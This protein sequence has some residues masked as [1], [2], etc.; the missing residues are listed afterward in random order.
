VERSADWRPGEVILDLYEVRGKTKG[1]MGVVYRVHHPVWGIDLA[2]KVPRPALLESPDALR[3]FETEAETWAGLGVHPHIVNCAYVRRI[4]NTPGVFAEWAAG[5]SVAEAIRSRSRSGGDRL[6]PVLDAAIQSAWGLAFAHGQG[7][8][9]QDVKPANLMFAADGTVKV[10][11]FG[12][13]RARRSAGESASDLADLTVSMG[14]RTPAYCSPEQA[15]SD[16]A[17]P[18]LTAATDVWSWAV[19]VIEMCTGER[20]SEHGEDAGKG[21]ADLR[22][23]G[24]RGLPP[25]PVAE[26]L[27]EC[28]REHPADRPSDLGAVAE[29][30]IE[31]HAE[32]VGR[33][34][35][36]R[37]PSQAR[38]LADGLSNRALSMLDLGRPE[39]SERLWEQA[40][41]V[42]PRHAHAVYNRGLHRWRR[43]RITDVEVV[44]ELMGIGRGHR[45]LLG[46]V[47][48]ERGASDIAVALFERAVQAD[49]GDAAAAAALAAARA[50]PAAAPPLTMEGHKSSIVSVAVSADGVLG[51]SLDAGGVL[52]T[53]DLATGECRIAI[54]VSENGGGT[55]ALAPDGSFAVV[56][57]GIRYPTVWD[58]SAP[59]S[60]LRL[61]SRL[62][63]VMDV[64][65]DG[66]RIATLGNGG[67]VRAWD[68]VSGSLLR[69]WDPQEF[70]R[71]ARPLAIDPTGTWRADL[72]DGA[73]I[74][75]S[76][77]D[78]P[79]D[80]QVLQ[81]WNVDVRFAASGCVVL[82]VA[83]DGTVRA[84]TL[85]RGEW[86]FAT[87]LRSARWP[88]QLS[89]DGR[90]AFGA[91]QWWD[92]AAA[93]CLS[94]GTRR[95]ELAALDHAGS[96]AWSALGTKVT[97][98]HRPAPFIAPWSYTR[99]RDAIVLATESETASAAIERSANLAAAGRLQEAAQ[100][101]RAARG[102]PGLRRDPRLS[103]RWRRLGVRAR[104]LRLEDAWSIG[105][106]Q[107]PS[108]Q[109]WSLDIASGGRLAL[110][111]SPRHRTPWVVDRVARQTIHPLRY[112]AG[113]VTAAAISDDGAVAV[114]AA[115]DARAIV[116]DTASGSMR[117]LIEVHQSPP[118]VA[119]VNRD[120][121]MTGSLSGE[122][123]IIDVERG[124]LGFHDAHAGSVRALALAS[125]GGIGLSS[126]E[127]GRVCSWDL[128]SGALLHVLSFGGT[129]AHRAALSRTGHR[130]V[131]WTTD[132]ELRLWNP[133]NGAS[134]AVLSGPRGSRP[135]ST[136]PHSRFISTREQSGRAAVSADGRWALT[137][138]RSGRLRTWDLDTGQCEQTLQED[139]LWVTALA[140]THDFSLAAV[141]RGGVIELWDPQA[142]N[143]V[144][145]IGPGPGVVTDLALAPDCTAMV[146]ADD[147]GGLREWA[148]D[149]EYAFPAE[150][151]PIDLAT[152]GRMPDA[153]P[154]DLPL[155]DRE[156]HTGSSWVRL[157]DAE[158]ARREL[159]RQVDRTLVQAVDPA[160]ESDC[161]SEAAAI[162]R[163]VALL[164]LPSAELSSEEQSQLSAFRQR[165]RDELA[166]LD[167]AASS[168]ERLGHHRDAEPL[169][170]LALRIRSNFDG[171]RALGTCTAGED[172]AACWS[173]LGRDDEAA[174]LLRA[175][176]TTAPL[177]AEVRPD[178]PA[179]LEADLERMTRRL[180]TLKAESTRLQE[181]QGPRAAM[182]PAETALSVARMITA[183]DRAGAP[184][185]A[186][187][188]AILGEL[189]AAAQLP[190]AAVRYLAEALVVSA[191][192]EQD[193]LRL[194]VPFDN[195][196]GLLVAAAY[197]IDLPYG[198]WFRSGDL[199][200][201]REAIDPSERGLLR[202]LM[203]WCDEAGAVF[204]EYRAP[205]WALFCHGA[206]MIVG[207]VMREDDPA[208]TGPLC[209]TLLAIAERKRAAGDPESGRHF[210]RRA[211][212]LAYN[213]CFE[214]EREVAPLGTLVAT[215]NASAP[216]WERLGEN[217]KARSAEDAAANLDANAAVFAREG[218]I[219]LETV[220]RIQDLVGEG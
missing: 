188:L 86:A 195:V 145:T 191:R 55:V 218:E 81:G 138:D 74:T 23:T 18:F 177:P 122:V 216:V 137:F 128:A 183:Q 37:L 158:L 133:R 103:E 26:L 201:V 172:L 65:I 8:V 207:E 147:K 57:D 154:A 60:P 215:L 68:P 59:T 13:A 193:G 9:H 24:A 164:D 3:D 108:D 160:M 213:A 71:G 46:L 56:V 66:R 54:P 102:L 209:E 105:G 48:R 181:I 39:Q 82:T 139:I 182:G 85:D 10:T 49:P 159:R 134:L 206:S 203:H 88:L 94:S 95:G 175:A 4:Q 211:I 184:N 41:E 163:A 146:A 185:L 73:R 197:G 70:I 47:H 31:L 67:T 124:L 100:V 192:T 27:A 214:V 189:S 126:G 152:A 116:W 144:H 167:E 80:R 198:A 58:L 40:L 29:R 161:S 83:D 155:G 132:D 99:P 63:R 202:E 170:R 171:V 33:P 72:H 217:A 91:G 98:D 121:A 131:L 157:L 113:P 150:G 92:L 130:A 78:D 76:G 194:I 38:L 106:I 165:V 62:E 125:G 14:G 50:A 87:D 123:G 140:V 109:D 84:F 7:V 61:G 174:A 115:S 2:V 210:L 79:D 69:T 43:G 208:F 212:G 149:W 186:L 127:D 178:G 89:G 107:A 44:Q 151:E 19:T 173:A 42:D 199:T 141:A 142:G 110:A 75:V 53:W 32:L 176:T 220:L 129:W 205:N 200:A 6:E 36:R 64:G 187:A 168:A 204:T 101:I 97:V 111:H 219:P 22:R 11:D 34:Y 30:L 162:A 35:Q 104:R 135:S 148:L 12:L 25:E 1:S 190:F 45:Y 96:V 5:G 20:P 15:A 17:A 93:R 119:A 166:A 180:G 179:V 21:F 136:R 52:R 153:G 28:L 156:D 120:A 114:T 90:T 117:H 118:M 196:A 77:I 143:L 112:H 16:D 169:R 51:A